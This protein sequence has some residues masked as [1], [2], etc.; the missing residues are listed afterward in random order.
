[1]EATPTGPDQTA[2]CC[3]GCRVL[4]A[5]PETLREDRI[6][7]PRNP[8]P[9]VRI[10]LGAA[11]AGQ[12]MVLGLTVNLSETEGTVRW[13]L[14]GALIASAL[15]V[16][17]LLGWPLFRA[18][19]DC[20][21]RR[22]V[23]VE[24]L[25]LSGVV[26]AFGASLWS[27]FS[28]VGAVYYEVVAVLLT[29][30]TGGK[31]LTA[32]A[33]SRAL[34]GTRSLGDTFRTAR[35]ED[36]RSVPVETIRPGDRVR[37]RPGEVIPVDGRVLA[38][39][40][41]V[42][43]T[44]LTGEPDPVVVRPGDAVHAGD[45][46]ED[47]ELLVESSASGTARR[48]DQLLASVEQA[49]GTLDGTRSQA[50]ADR[51]AGVFLPLVLLTAL[52]TFGWWTCQGQW[53]E[54]LFHGLS[55]LLVAC[56]CAL[57]LATPLGLWQALVQ[58]A[59]HGVTVRDAAVVERLAEIDTVVLDKTGTITEGRMSL[60]DFVSLGDAT[61]RL[62]LLR[63]VQAVEQRSGHPVARA[64][65]RDETAPEDPSIVV[66][67]FR[68]VPARGV[69]ALVQE[70]SDG[71]R[72]IRIG[73][74]DWIVGGSDS[75]VAGP[76]LA[77]IRAVPGTS[78]VWV[79]VDDKPAAIASVR[80]R[81]RDSAA[82]AVRELRGIGVAV[83]VLSGDHATRV[84]AVTREVAGQDA[85]LESR[86]AQDPMEKAT[87]LREL[88]AAGRRTLFLGDGLNDAPGLGAAHVGLAVAEGAS[89][90]VATADGVLHGG[91]LRSV[92]RAV[93]VARSVAE[94]IRG[95][96]RFA[97]A[98]NG[99]GMALA[100]TGHLHPIAAALL[101]AGS[102]VVVGW[103]SWRHDGCHAA[104]EPDRPTARWWIPATLLLQIPMLMGLG[105][106][107]SGPSLAIALLMA[108]LAAGALVWSR[109]RPEMGGGVRATGDMTLA[110][111]GPAGLGMLLGWWVEAGFQPVMR[112][113]VCLCCSGHA[114]FG[115][116]WKIPW[117]PL[118]MLL[119][120]MPGMW[121]TLSRWDG[122]WGRITA[123]GIVAAGMTAGMSGGAT[124][125][126]RIAG[127]MHPWQF[128]AVFLGMTVGMLAGMYFACALA[129]AA[130]PAW[131]EI[132]R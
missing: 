64:F 131:K 109:R 107:A 123:A 34:A 21:C 95:N 106:L 92:F 53:R 74:A 54:G 103:R 66:V 113:G 69:E 121:G 72:R 50:Q 112:D 6:D 37:I 102:S 58:L 125:A 108:S 70:G 12:A 128:P 71:T 63:I 43:G 93:R 31:A 46:S 116:G 100:A 80:E 81:V 23:G 16:T 127:P 14:H 117:M 18:G 126:L 82:E 97:A 36:G 60:V 98:Y 25:F 59:A 124:L 39:E 61:E 52:G 101:M 26:G 7:A 40:A 129:E 65:H 19:W 38:G 87:R 2:F 30:Y 35:L 48:I 118:G 111:L 47:A 114:Y 79:S 29:V 10:G 62:R 132:G 44:P 99:V 68:A 119:A 41:F 73:T 67:S 105:R 55:V 28:G 84:A 89:L 42:R 15:A 83:E 115:A 104:A 56:P 130:R 76:L 32:A 8:N 13:A 11:I 24:W 3:Y 110:M 85:P 78:T 20:A 57:G 94:S 1:M 51:L 120:G 9:W 4:G 122:R 27:T 45:F 96:L 88:A 86:G 91:D 5:R 49:R 75:A 22:T 77:R 17:V 90:A 33:R